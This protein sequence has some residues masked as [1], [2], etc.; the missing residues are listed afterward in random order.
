MVPILEDGPKRV[1]VV[2]RIHDNIAGFENTAVVHVVGDVVE[3]E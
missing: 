3:V 2:K 1:N